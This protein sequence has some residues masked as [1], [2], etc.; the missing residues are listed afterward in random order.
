MFTLTRTKTARI[1]L[2]VPRD[3][4]VN[5]KFLGLSDALWKKGT[6]VDS[7]DD[8]D[9]ST[10]PTDYFVDSEVG[11]DLHIYHIFQNINKK[12]NDSTSIHSYKFLDIIIALFIVFVLG[13][14]SSKRCTL[15]STPLQT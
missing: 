12:H 13:L 14:C 11:Y 3:A 1:G 5:L 4:S 9:A 6:Q 10:N 8:L 7:L 2:C 15:V